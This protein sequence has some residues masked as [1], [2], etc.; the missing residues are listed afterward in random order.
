MGLKGKNQQTGDEA[1]VFDQFAQLRDWH[2]SGILVCPFCDELLVT[3]REHMREGDWVKN[4]LRHKGE[5]S[6]TLAHHP[7]S[8]EHFAAKQWIMEHM[9]EKM[10]Y[11]IERAD[12]EV[13][14]P[15]INRIADVCFWI[16]GGD[17]VVHEAQ[18]AAISVDEL[19]ART[20][21]YQSIG[22]GIV[23]HFGKSAD[24]DTNKRWAFRRLGGC[25]VLTLDEQIVGF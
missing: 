20:N 4:Y 22:Y 13:R 12:C 5:C 23:W 21:D 3:V 14:M 10:A 6:T 15:E 8:P 16:D 25:E 1:L 9:P 2:H 19:E 7:Q 11:V 17:R 18:L 24:T